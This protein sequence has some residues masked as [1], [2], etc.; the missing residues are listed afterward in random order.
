MGRT[1][2]EV[3]R[4]KRKNG[5]TRRVVPPRASPK[6]HVGAWWGQGELDPVQE[7]FD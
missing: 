6:L 5:F 3:N 2:Q 1:G 7:N 4:N